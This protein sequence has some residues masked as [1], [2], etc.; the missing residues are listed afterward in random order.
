[1]SFS[2][3]ERDTLTAL[4]DQIIPPS[5][6]LPGAGELG[7]AEHIDAALEQTP[8]LR[9]LIAQGLASLS[10][11]GFCEAEVDD[12]LEVLNRVAPQEPALVPSLVF[13]TYMAYYSHGRV[14]EALGMEARAP[15]PQGYEMEPSDFSLLDPV[16]ARSR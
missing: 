10:A 1:M 11:Q 6:E 16:R 9:P 2:K 4:L 7:L 14:V 12:R 3:H 5:A 15:F 8:D 13:H